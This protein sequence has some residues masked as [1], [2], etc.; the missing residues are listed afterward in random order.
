M[1][2]I[3]L[4]GVLLLG[5]V[6]GWGLNYLSDVL[7]QTRKFGRPVC[8]HCGK[9]YGWKDYLFSLRCSVCG[10]KKHWRFLTVQILSVIAVIT[11]WLIPPVY[12]GFWKSV[13]FLT[14]LGLVVISDFEYRIIIFPVTIAGAF[15]ALALGLLENGWQTT[16]IGGGFGFAVM[17]ALY[18]LGILFARIM[19]KKR[20][21]P[22]DEVA[23][24]FGDVTL[25]GVLGLAFGYPRILVLLFMAILAGGVISGLIILI[26]VIRKKYSAFSA[27]PYA[28]FLAIAALI[29][30]Y[31]S[32]R[33]G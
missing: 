7:P 4:T 25:T 30:L 11:L 17:W 21:L 10:E 19:A 24:G 9:I 3:Y 33:G 12:F 23:L 32:G 29:M 1:W 8:S 31:M 27:L 20:G 14:F 2:F 28:P 26:N 15:I 18:G 5:W 6:L 22:E 16:L 13:L